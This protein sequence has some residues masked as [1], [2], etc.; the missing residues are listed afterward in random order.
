MSNAH[1]GQ[2]LSEDDILNTLG[3]YFPMRRHQG[4]LLSRGDDCALLAPD[5]ALAVSSDLFLQDVHFR[6]EYATAEEIGHKALACNISDLA[7]CG[8][9]PL[10]FT[11]NL[12]LPSSVEAGWLNEFFGGMGSLASRYNITLVG[13]DL[14]RTDR[15]QVS[16][17]VFGEVVGEG[18][19]LSRGGSMPG[20]VIFV[21]GTLG[22]A[23]VGLQVMEKDGREAMRAW[24]KACKALLVPEP[25]VDAGLMLA[26]AGMNSRPPALMDVS[27]GLAR[28]L[29]RLLG[30]SG[31]ESVRAS[32]GP[33]FGAELLIPAGLLHR[34]VVDWCRQNGRNPV[35]EAIL[36][37]DE[38]ALL[39]SCAPDMLP[40]LHAAIPEFWEIGVVTDT[41][42]IYCNNE[43]IDG[44]KGFDHF[45]VQQQGA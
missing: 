39:G 29:P 3:R 34:E 25:R 10:A 6:M 5:R 43:R 12:G 37:G 17:T 41:G 44:L 36:G 30:L 8:T 2:L 11:L 24:P 33:G 14:S 7:A 15:L 1:F 23:R 27:D 42:V 35:H 20:D 4:V 40:A 31:E 13:G 38:Y 45:A 21:V 19:F 26:R 18:G 16:I 28:D 22:L 9:R 32:E